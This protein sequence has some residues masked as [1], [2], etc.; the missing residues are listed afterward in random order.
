M[1]RPAD[2]EYV[3]A[4]PGANHIIDAIRPDTGRTWVN[5]H[6]L[7]EIQARE[8][9]AVLMTIEAFLCEKAARQQTPIVWTATTAEQYDEMLGVL[10]PLEFRADGF[11]VGE[12]CDHCAAT[13]RPRYQGFRQRAGRYERASRPM[14]CAEFRAEL[15]RTPAPP[16][17]APIDAVIEAPCERPRGH[18]GPCRAFSLE[19]GPA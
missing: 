13:G 19:E 4:V 6:T 16:C 10:P 11:L 17:G 18:L 7:A 15:G 1:S 9:G 3:I 2:V 5:G 14:T 12:P 8:P